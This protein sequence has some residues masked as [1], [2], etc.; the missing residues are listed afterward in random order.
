MALV[1]KQRQLLLSVDD[2]Q[3]YDTRR[4]AGKGVLIPVWYKLD[5]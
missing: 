4:I 1:A 5:T 3:C 2:T